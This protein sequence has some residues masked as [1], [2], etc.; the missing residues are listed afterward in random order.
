MPRRSRPL[1]RKAAAAADDGDADWVPDAPHTQQKGGVT[2]NATATAAAPSVT[3]RQAVEAPSSAA[4]AAPATQPPPQQMLSPSSQASLLAAFTAAAA[5]IPL[6]PLPPAAAASSGAAAP[7]AAPAAPTAAAASPAAVPLAPPHVASTATATATSF[8]ASANGVVSSSAAAAAA[9]PL[10]DAGAAVWAEAER[11]RFGR[12]GAP[13]DEQMSFQFC[14]S[15]AEAGNARAM[16]RAAFCCYYG[17]GCPP[18]FTQA[19][20]WFERAAAAGSVRAVSFLADAYLNG[21]WWGLRDEAKH[22]QL[23]KQQF[24]IEHLLTNADIVPNP[25]AK[26]GKVFRDVQFCSVLFC[27]VR[28]HHCCVC[29]SLTPGG[30]ALR[31]QRIC[32]WLSAM[33]QRKGTCVRTSRWRSRWSTRK[34]ARKRQILRKLLSTVAAQPQ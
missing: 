32:W 4:A 5:A 33:P 14:E 10:A 15:A 19:F 24:E 6:P 23:L 8:A 17:I 27:P 30:G 12:N 26:I 9:A 3:N 21:G 2:P 7:A 11:Y 34:L 22:A 31:L 13:I 25:K 20:R 16:C 28:H 29:W 18:N 1:K